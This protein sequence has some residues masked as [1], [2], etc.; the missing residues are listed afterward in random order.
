MF[1]PSERKRVFILLGMIMTMVL[2]EMIGVASFMPFMKVLVS[3]ELVE[4]NALLN[5]AFKSA[6]RFGTHTTDQFLFVLGILVFLLFL[7]SLA[8]GSL[9]SMQNFA[10]P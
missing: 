2:L 1:A 10:L 4:T 5:K 7:V 9:P 8:L 3:P 6:N